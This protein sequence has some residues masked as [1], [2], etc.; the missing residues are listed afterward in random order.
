MRRPRVLIIAAD[1]SPRALIRAQLREAGY[2][3]VGAA[4]LRTALSQ[5]LDAPEL[6]PV[7][8]VLVDQATLAAPAAPSLLHQL[9]SKHPRGRLILLARGTGRLPPGRWDAVLRRPIRVGEIVATVERLAPLRPELRGS[10]NE[11]GH[12]GE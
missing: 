3:A 12:E 7:D 6:G 8:A 11:Q 10:I 9:A 4:S 1:R 5:P 2:D